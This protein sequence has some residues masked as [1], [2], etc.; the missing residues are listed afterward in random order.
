MYCNKLPH[1]QKLFFRQVCL[2]R[3]GRWSVLSVILEKSD[4]LVSR[5]CSDWQMNKETVL[6]NELVSYPYSHHHIIMLCLGFFNFSDNNVMFYHILIKLASWN[7][8]SLNQ[9]EQACSLPLFFLFL[10]V[11]HKS[12]ITLK[13]ITTFDPRPC[14]KMPFHCSETIPNSSVRTG[15]AGLK[16]LIRK[17]ISKCIKQR[18][19]QKVAD[20]TYILFTDTSFSCNHSG[21]SV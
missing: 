19:R 11:G 10:V 21:L 1:H 8:C 16:K 2:W 7:C 9:S 15:Q 20:I 14:D 6:L 12:T 13:T 5:W 3:N 4:S 17:E 18:N